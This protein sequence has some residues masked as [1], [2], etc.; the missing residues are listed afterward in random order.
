M[1]INCGYIRIDGCSYVFTDGTLRYVDTR[2]PV[3]VPVSKRCA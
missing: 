2:N 3:R 1:E